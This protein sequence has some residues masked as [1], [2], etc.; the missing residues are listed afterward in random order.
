MRQN[1]KTEF[2]III[3]TLLNESFKINKQNNKTFVYHKSKLNNLLLVLALGALISTC[4]VTLAVA[5]RLYIR[6]A[7][8]AHGTRH[9]DTAAVRFS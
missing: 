5:V 1:I 2:A 8:A 7:A 6:P 3:E 9:G 4:H